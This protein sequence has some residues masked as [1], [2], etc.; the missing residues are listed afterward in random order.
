MAYVNTGVERCITLQI[1]KYINGNMVVGYP[2][3]LGILYPFTYNG[4][5][6]GNKSLDTFQKMSLA[7]YTQRVNAFK[8][9]VAQ[10]EGITDINAVT[11]IGYEPSRENLT[12][13]PLPV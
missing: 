12:A 1:N 13:C 9:Y 5:Y 2:K 4:I 10:S 6:Y 11:Q 8:G 7:D 3:Y